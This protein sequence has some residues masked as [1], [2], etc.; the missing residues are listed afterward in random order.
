MKYK[1]V[2]RD[3]A[4][5]EMQVAYNWYENEVA[6]IGDKFISVVNDYKN[7]ILNNPLQ[8]KRTYQN[9]REVYIQKYP[10]VIVYFIDKPKRT[11]VIFSVFHTSRNPK[12]K[13]K[14]TD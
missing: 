7:F 11:I 8:F 1:L 13:F 3:R 14:I 2:V 6:G 5:E 4:V 10:F 12:R 9:F